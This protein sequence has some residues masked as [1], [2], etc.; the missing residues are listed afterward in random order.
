RLSPDGRF[1]TYT[2]QKA[3][4]DDVYVRRFDPSIPQAGEELKVSQGGGD[5]GNWRADG[6]EIFYRAPDGAIM[7]VNVTT[8]PALQ[9]GTPR[10]LFRSEATFADWAVAPDGQ[11]FLIPVPVE[12]DAAAPYTVVLN[13]Q[14]SL[15]R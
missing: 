14:A 5:V 2:S 15:K 8:S 9:L 11:R 1:L 7:A 12:N 6:K 4:Q 10:V 13:W 3:G